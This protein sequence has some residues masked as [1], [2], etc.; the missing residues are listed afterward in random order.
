MNH[1]SKISL[2]RLATCHIDL[3]Q[4][5]EHAIDLSAVDFGVAEGH[6][7]IADQQR[8]FATG[9]SKVNGITVK[10]KHNE[11]PALA[12]DIYA[13]VNGK[14]DYS[15]HHLTYLAGIIH[16]VAVMLYMNNQ[17]THLVRWGGN[18]DRDGEI[19]TDQA[20]DDLVH[21]EL[22]TPTEP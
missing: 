11:L 3:R 7:T 6:R 16:A 14:A 19:I 5:M 13:Y 4:I 8:Y 15:I 18:W 12:V 21:F 2:A 20:F 17:T 1:F 22:Y 10:S 9:K